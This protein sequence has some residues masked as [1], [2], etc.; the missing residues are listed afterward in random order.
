MSP[1]QVIAE[2]LGQRFDAELIPSLYAAASVPTAQV[3][4]ELRAGGYAF[5]DE[6]AGVVPEADELARTVAFLARQSTRQATALGVVSGAAGLFALAPE[7][8]A[9][10]VAT[11][12][13]AQRLAVVYGFDPETDAGRVVLSRALA[14][15]YEIKLPESARV[16]TRVSEIEALVR[17]SPAESRELVA[18]AGRRALAGSAGLVLSRITRLVPGLGAI[19]GGVR[20]FRTQ[21][22][23][24]ARMAEVYAGA[25][26]S[27][28]FDLRGE[29]LA[30]ELR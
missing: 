18:W 20:A 11:L 7:V 29:E 28:P 12:R 25:A 17:S 24:A 22:R 15:A 30:V 23:L 1:W 16:A 2:A 21:G 6:V 27:V 10:G 19:V 3:H 14:H 5:V 9:G 8:V 26:E 4:D 13:L